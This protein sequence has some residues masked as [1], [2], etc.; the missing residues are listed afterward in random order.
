MVWPREI[1]FRHAWTRADIVA[2]KRVRSRKE[3]Y[4]LRGVLVFVVAAYRLLV[5]YFGDL[6]G[7]SWNPPGI[8]SILCHSHYENSSRSVP[9]A[10]NPSLSFVDYLRQFIDTFVFS[11]S[12]RMRKLSK[13]V[14]SSGIFT[15]NDWRHRLSPLQLWCW[16]SCVFGQWS[17]STSSL[18]L[19]LSSNGGRNTR[20]RVCRGSINST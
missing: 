10:V 7:C 4:Y 19:S 17:V 2:K 16:P 5:T 12:Y 8:W 11:G 1:P 15:W 9:L 18:H 20:G 6:I 13:L 14:Y 3:R